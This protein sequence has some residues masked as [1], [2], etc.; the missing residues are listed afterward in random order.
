MR[1]G[2][3]VP[4]CTLKDAVAW[5]CDANTGTVFMLATQEAC[6]M[7]MW[8]LDTLV[9]VRTSLGPSACVYHGDE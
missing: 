7:W 9:E 1:A 5:S 3:R 8:T 6:R 4:R 2:L